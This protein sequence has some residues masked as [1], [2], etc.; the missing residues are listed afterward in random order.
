MSILLHTLI[1][2]SP[3]TEYAFQLNFN[4]KNQKAHSTM[5]LVVANTHTGCSYRKSYL[6]L[7]LFGGTRQRSAFVR[8]LVGWSASWLGGSNRRMMQPGN[9][10]IKIN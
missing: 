1:V 2:Y 4:A 6:L 8:R 10:V 5:R 3:K 9:M 7:L